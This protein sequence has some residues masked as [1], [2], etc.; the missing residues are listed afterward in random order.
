M[1]LAGVLG[2][3]FSSHILNEQTEFRDVM[4][5]P[6]NPQTFAGSGFHHC[7]R[8]G[9]VFLVDVPEMSA[10]IA[11]LMT[12]FTPFLGYMQYDLTFIGLDFQM[13][14]DFYLIFNLPEAAIPIP[15]ELAGN[16]H[17]IGT[18]RGCT[19][20]ESP[21]RPSTARVF[22]PN[23]VLVLMEY[24]VPEYE[25]WFKEVVGPTVKKYGDCVKLDEQVNEWRTEMRSAMKRCDAVLLDLSHDLTAGL[26]PN[27][28]WELTTTYRAAADEKYPRE[29]ILC[30]ARGLE[31]VKS[32]DPDEHFVY[33]RDVNPG[34]LPP[35]V[36]DHLSRSLNP[37]D[38]L[39]IRIRRYDPHDEA[40]RA[41]FIAW[42]ESSLAPWVQ[43]VEAPVTDGQ[44]RARALELAKAAYPGW[45][46][47]EPL[48]HETRRFASEMCRLD[49]AQL[50]AGWALAI[51]YRDFEAC[52]ELFS[53]AENS[54]EP[55]AEL[56]GSLLS[57]ISA[58]DVFRYHGY[59]TMARSVIVRSP[60]LRSHLMNVLKTEHIHR[61]HYLTNAWR[62]DAWR[63]FARMPL[64]T[65]D[66]SRLRQLA[67][68]EGDADT[69]LTIDSVLI[70]F[71]PEEEQVSER[72]RMTKRFFGVDLFDEQTR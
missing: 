65:S 72:V 67:D 69:R 17:F 49:G 35:T 26:S 9:G 60:T 29:K 55:V 24:G 71:L 22:G 44:L 58:T 57:T 64:S 40:G 68:Q 31:N 20:P 48:I 53:K 63:C 10:D 32:R 8:D 39:G 54:P 19:G 66:V 33:S 38:L 62:D 23:K 28:L 61:N 45:Y 12:M 18:E 36:S 14:P 37:E 3:D 50:L 4:G 25:S 13:H 11:H 27:M 16:I 41:G 7:L 42:L 2:L 52:W 51:A 6:R 15:S 34:W 56:L 46:E 1:L 70:S 59:W 43:G 5:D 30:F 21:R 47:L